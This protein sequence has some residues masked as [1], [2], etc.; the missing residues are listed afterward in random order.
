MNFNHGG[1]GKRV[2]LAS[3]NVFNPMQ[4]RGFGEDALT[5]TMKFL[6]FFQMRH[7]NQ[8]TSIQDSKELFVKKRQILESIETHSMV[9]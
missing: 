9:Q 3:P 4:K 8:T 6:F 1:T 2:G 7:S 5:Q